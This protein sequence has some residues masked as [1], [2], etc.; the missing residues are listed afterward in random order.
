MRLDDEHFSPLH[1]DD[2]DQEL[3]DYL[4]SQIQNGTIS[5]RTQLA[6]QA[7]SNAGA[8]AAPFIGSFQSV[9]ERHYDGIRDGNLELRV[10]KRRVKTFP[11]G[12]DHRVRLGD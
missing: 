10:D 11:K 9:V 8:Y 12:F 5:K 6:F 7:P 3:A 2:F 1:A 4:V